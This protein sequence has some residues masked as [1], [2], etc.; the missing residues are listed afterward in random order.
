MARR[1]DRDDGEDGEQRSGQPGAGKKQS[2]PA[3]ASPSDQ[4]ADRGDG[5]AE[6]LLDEQQRNREPGRRPPTL[7]GQGDQ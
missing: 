3:C 6:I 1:Q 7:L 2:D 4:Q 5:E